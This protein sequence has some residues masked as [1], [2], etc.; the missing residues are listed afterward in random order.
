[1]P[2]IGVVDDRKDQRELLVGQIRHHLRNYSEWEALET[3]PFEDINDY[4]SW[5]SENNISVLI[6]DERLHE[7][8]DE[9]KQLKT[10]CC[11]LNTRA[12]M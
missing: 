10:L 1:M 5:I 6:L 7:G 9:Q 12:I 11:L 3:P 8:I 2:T 4:P